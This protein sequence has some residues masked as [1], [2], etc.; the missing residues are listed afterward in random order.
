MNINNTLIIAVVLSLLVGLLA[1]YGIW[2]GKRDK[3]VDVRQLLQRVSEKVEAIQRENSDLRSMNEKNKETIEKASALVKKNENLQ[4]QLQEA[5]LKIERLDVTVKQISGE[6][7]QAKEQAEEN[8]RMRESREALEDR[9]ASL[10]QENYE[11]RMKLEQIS[12]ITGRQEEEIAAPIQ[13]EAP[14]QSEQ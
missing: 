1:G 8:G 13:E 4:K 11:L 2:G 12:T 7:A 3:D 14:V 10:E 5:D 9:A 6:L